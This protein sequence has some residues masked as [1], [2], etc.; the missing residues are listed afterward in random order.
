MSLLAVCDRLWWPAGPPGV[1][2]QGGGNVGV[3]GQAQDGGGQI[4]QCRV[5]AT[6]H[7]PMPLTFQVFVPLREV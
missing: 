4:A 7:R 5:L 6:T 3:P 1:V 2:A